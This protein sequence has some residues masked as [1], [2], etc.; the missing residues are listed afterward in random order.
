MS[1]KVDYNLFNEE[2]NFF[3]PG[4]I[5]Q[6]AMNDKLFIDRYFCIGD[7]GGYIYEFQDRLI[8]IQ[9]NL[10]RLHQL[11]WIDDILTFPL[12][13]F[14]DVFRFLLMHFDMLRKISY[15]LQ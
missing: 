3:Q 2:Q 14:I 1:C 10:F 13:F 5:D 9:T 15:S 11:R 8:N 6:T 12:G 4:W 7:H